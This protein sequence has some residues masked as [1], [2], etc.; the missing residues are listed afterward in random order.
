MENDD[1]NI[2]DIYKIY[3]QLGR[4]AFAYVK[5]AKNRKT[6]QYFAVKIYSKEKMLDSDRE[7][8]NT[9]IEILK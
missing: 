6:G 9:E 2:R 8:M 1:V 7:S 3:E 4:G 5:K